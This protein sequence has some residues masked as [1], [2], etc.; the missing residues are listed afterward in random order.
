MD[1]EVI[2]LSLSTIAELNPKV[3]DL[4]REQIARATRDCIERCEINKARKVKIQIEVTPEVEDGICEDVNVQ[5][6]ID[7]ELPPR[8]TRAYRMGVRK[9]DFNPFF[10]PDNPDN[11]RQRGLGFD[12]D[13][14]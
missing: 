3:D 4:V 5:I 2:S 14:R 1:R 8:R 11:I 13:D 6:F 9:K 10:A 12:G 7:D